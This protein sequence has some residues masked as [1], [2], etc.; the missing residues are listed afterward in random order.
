[1]YKLGA[2]LMLFVLSYGNIP[3]HLQDKQ[4]PYLV[5]HPELVDLELLPRKLELNEDPD[6]LRSPYTVGSK[7]YFR[8][9][10]TNRYSQTVT[11]LIIDSY[12]QERPELFRDGQLVPYK[13]GVDELLSAKDKDPFTRLVQNVT[14]D[15]NESKVIGFL[16]LNNW[17]GRLLPGHYQLSTKHRFE[18]G[19]QWIESSALTFEVITE[20]KEPSSAATTLT[21]EANSLTMRNFDPPGESIATTVRCAAQGSFSNE[22]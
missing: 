17:Y 10:A 5:E 11:I 16:D 1:M 19:Q 9:Q 20:H 22:S 2:I 14:L 8:I 13:K 7:L 21:V 4:T 15:P 6:A 18:P 3:G 12:V